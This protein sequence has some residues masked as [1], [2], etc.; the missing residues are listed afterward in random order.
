MSDA[1]DAY[2][3]KSKRGEITATVPDFVARCIDAYRANFDPA[4][5]EAELARM[6]A[7]HDKE[8]EERRSLS[9]P[10]ARKKVDARLAALE[11]RMEALQQQQSDLAGRVEMQY[12]EV[13]ALRDAITSA[14]FAS[15]KESGER[16]MRQRA[17]MIRAVV[18]RIECSFTATGKT[19]GGP[20]QRN[21]RLVK[22]TIYPLVGAATDYAVGNVLRQS[23]EVSRW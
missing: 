21:A 16:A 15:R 19:G 12:R 10:L 8:L 18:H 23:S 4:M 2:C 3:E 13:A 1:H 20:G 22:V 17:E 6:N 14:K 7:E 5:I 11:A 9:T